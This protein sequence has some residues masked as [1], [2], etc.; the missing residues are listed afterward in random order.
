MDLLG[1]VKF[2]SSKMY[3]ALKKFFLDSQILNEIY[4]EIDKNLFFPAT[5]DERYLYIEDIKEDD[6]F[7]QFI[8]LCFKNA[9]LDIDISSL[10]QDHY[11]DK[12]NEAKDYIKWFYSQIAL[13]IYGVLKRHASLEGKILLKSQ[14]IQLKTILDR[15]DEITSL[16]NLEKNKNILVVTYSANMQGKQWTLNRIVPSR[17]D[18]S[19]KNFPIQPD[20][21]EFWLYAQKSLMAE[22]NKRV[23]AFLDDGYAVDLYALAPIPLLVLLGNLFANRPNINIFQLKKVPSSFAWEEAGKKLNIIVTQIPDVFH[24]EEAGLL[25]SFSGKVN[26]NNIVKIIGD[27]IPLIEMSIKEPFDDF[28]RT[29]SQLDEFLT[30]YRK[31][32][33]SLASKGITKIHLFAAIPIAFAIGIGQAYNPNYDPDIITYDFRQGVYSKALTI[34]GNHGFKQ[35]TV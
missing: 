25:M 28:L 8:D 24:G 2:G 18:L 26:K 12:T 31:V 33:S 7:D 3:N 32:K 1:I 19:M 14:E 5:Q 30:E 21:K 13:T 9:S 6:I 29:K 20:S 34:G 15:I 16:L 22:F 27:K 23:L 4:D 35:A 10:A 17:V 11:K